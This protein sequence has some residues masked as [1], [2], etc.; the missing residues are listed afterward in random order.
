MQHEALEHHPELRICTSQAT[1]NASDQSEEELALMNISE[2]NLVPTFL[3]LAAE[4]TE[5]FEPRT[6]QQAKLD[7][8]WLEWERAMLNEVNSLKQNKTWELVD[9]PKDRRILNGKWVFKLKRGPHGEVA[10]YKSRWVVR[11]FTQ[12]QGI[13]Y[14]ETFASVVKPMSYKALFA[15]AA[16]LDLEIEQIDVKTAFLYGYIDH[17]IYVEQPNHMDDG[18]FRVCKLRKALY[19]LKQAPRI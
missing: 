10:R 14:D 13:D 18:T 1:A 15:I 16:A 11:G 17:E 12:E 19:G 8:S 4:G 3:T 2:E 5:P 6:L 9:P 7:S